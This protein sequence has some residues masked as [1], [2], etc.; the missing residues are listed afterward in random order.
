MKLD[1][2]SEIS[3]FLIEFK[4]DNAVSASGKAEKAFN[5]I[6]LLKTSMLET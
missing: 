2:S 6:M 5:F 1:R 4:L 3:Q